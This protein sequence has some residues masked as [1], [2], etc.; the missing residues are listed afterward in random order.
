MQVIQS[1]LLIIP[2][3]A[4][5]GEKIYF[6]QDPRI[7]GSI[8]KGIMIPNEPGEIS[9]KFKYYNQLLAK[10]LVGGPKASPF[11]ITLCNYKGE[12]LHKNLVPQ[13]FIVSRNKGK[14]F[15]HFHN[16]IDLK[17]CYVQ[18]NNLPYIPFPPQKQRG[19]LFNFLL[20][21]PD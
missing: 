12:E 4:V 6:E 13:S 11:F 17:K 8:L 7:S 18:F 10:P 9:D 15:K 16:N 20:Q 14:I 2:L 21:R 1:Q 5:P 3:T 19:I